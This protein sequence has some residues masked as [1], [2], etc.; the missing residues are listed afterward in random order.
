MRCCF[1]FFVAYMRYCCYHHLVL[2]HTTSSN[3][4]ETPASRLKCQCETKETNTVLR[5]LHVSC[6]RRVSAEQSSAFY[7][8]LLLT[9]Q[10]FYQTSKR[11]LSPLPPPSLTTFHPPLR[12]PYTLF[13][14]DLGYT[15][16]QIHSFP[17]FLSLLPTRCY[18]CSSYLSSHLSYH[19]YQLRRTVGSHQ[20]AQAGRQPAT[21]A[22]LVH[23][24]SL[25]ARVQMSYHPVG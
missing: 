24:R 4:A 2:L 23:A 15:R 6:K 18:Q 16:L 1:N 10:P 25:I 3:A 7:G 22:I 20:P 11:A 13:I 12:T 21:P 19:C 8:M 5:L 17:A 14:H 9:A